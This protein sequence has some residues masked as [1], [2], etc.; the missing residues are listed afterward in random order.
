MRV[1]M[2]ANAHGPPVPADATGRA[3]Y[4]VIQKGGDAS[5]YMSYM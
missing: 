1:Q 5:R 4:Y 2:R 3:L